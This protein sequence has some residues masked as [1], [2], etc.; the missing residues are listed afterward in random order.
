MSNEQQLSNT[1]L[2][3]QLSSAGYVDI[4][5]FIT[6]IYSTA[7][8]AATNIVQPYITNRKNEHALY[9]HY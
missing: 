4:I 1:Y 2:W 6:A 9:V 7:Q 8:D 5:L 3:L